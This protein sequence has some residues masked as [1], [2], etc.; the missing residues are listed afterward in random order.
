MASPGFHRPSGRSQ[1]VCMRITIRSHKKMR[2]YSILR[3]FFSLGLIAC[4]CIFL[5]IVLSEEPN[6]RLLYKLSYGY[7]KILNNVKL[8]ESIAS[9]IRCGRITSVNDLNQF[10]FQSTAVFFTNKTD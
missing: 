9:C 8:L 7:V 5:I 2:R 10:V 4:F 6:M 1:H 3:S